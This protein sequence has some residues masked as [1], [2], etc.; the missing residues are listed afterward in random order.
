[1]HMTLKIIS[2]NLNSW[3]LV[4][5][6]GSTIPSIYFNKQLTIVDSI[7]EGWGLRKKI[8]RHFLF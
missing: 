5:E 7:M 4:L 2:T 8:F 1:M 6:D 3:R